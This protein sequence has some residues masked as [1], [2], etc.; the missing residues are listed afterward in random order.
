MRINR[1]IVLASRPLSYPVTENFSLRT[2]PLPL[3]QDG[4][5]LLETLYISLDPYVRGRM[6]EGRSYL[7]P[8]AIGDVISAGGVSRVL[9]S[10]NPRFPVG[11]LVFSFTGWQEFSVA[12]SQDVVMPIDPQLAQSSWAL[13]VLGMPAL[14]AY[15]GITDIGRPRAGETFV[16]SA[17]AGAVGS[18]ALQIAKLK[19]CRVVGIAGSKEKCEAVRALGVDDCVDHSSPDFAANLT[20][21]CPKGIDVYFENVGGRIFDVVFPLLNVHAR[22]PLCGMSTIYNSNQMVDRPDKSALIMAGIL[23]RRIRLQGFMSFDQNERFL[24]F[25]QSMVSWLAKGQVRPFDTIHDGLER[26]PAVFM[27]QLRGHSMGKQIV[28]VKPE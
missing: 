16:A 21:A 8:L 9:D 28:R 27:E 14:T 4:Q 13:S 1:Q 22:V 23:T 3:L 24:E 11:G 20:R 25:A 12:G 18:I 7:P 2:T 15:L 6:N 19:G 5:L 17:A 10:R 26:A